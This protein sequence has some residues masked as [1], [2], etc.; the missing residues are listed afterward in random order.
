MSLAELKQL[1]NLSQGDID[2]LKGI[3]YKDCQP[4]GDHLFYKGRDD[5]KYAQTSFKFRGRLFQMRKAQLSLFLKL[6]DI[7]FDMNTWDE[8]LSTSH[9]CHRKSCLE[10]EHLHLETYE[11]NRERDECARA[12]RCVGHKEMP[13]CIV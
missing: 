7:D 9:L 13:K 5:Q 4:I 2:H 6:K 8:T 12:R 3:C 1:S 10:K 11:H